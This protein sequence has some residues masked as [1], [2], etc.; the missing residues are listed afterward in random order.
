VTDE[1]RSSATFRIFQE[2]LTNVAHHAKATKVTVCLEKVNGN[3]LLSVADNGR[4]ISEKD[5]SKSQCFGLIGMK[6]RVH[7]FGGEFKINGS[8]SKGTTIIVTIPI[9]GS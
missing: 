4:G 1:K 7:S 2:A 9:G 8:P 6:E 5:I 3:I